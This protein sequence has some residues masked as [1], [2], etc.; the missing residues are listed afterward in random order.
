VSFPGPTP[1][2]GPAAGGGGYDRPYRP[3]PASAIARSDDGTK[4][5]RQ[6]RMI[7]AAIVVLVAVVSTLLVWV[8]AS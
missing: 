2:Q 4:A 6:R 5:R 1:N 3:E 7:L 8:S